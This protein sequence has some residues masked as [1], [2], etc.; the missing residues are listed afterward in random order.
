[1]TAASH[2]PVGA[3]RRPASWLDLVAHDPRPWLRTSDEPFARWVALTQLDDRPA[4]N[5]AAREAHDL[6]LAHPSVTALVDRLPEWTDPVRSHGAPAYAPNLLNLLADLGVSDE[7]GL[8][9]VTR[10]L[11]AMLEHRTPQGRF[12]AFATFIRQPEPAWSTLACDHYVITEVLVRFGREDDPRVQ[13][14]LALIA[15]DIVDTSMGVGCRCLPHSRTR[16][17]GPGR[18]ADP[19][20]Q[21]TAEAL[22]VLSRVRRPSVRTGHGLADAARTLLGVWRGRGDAKPYMFGHGLHFK[23]VK[24]PNIW[25]SSLTVLDALAAVPE[26]WHPSTADPTDSEAAAQLVACLAAYN[27]GADGRVVPRSVYRGFGEF[28]FG[29]KKHPSPIATAWVA[30]ALR[31]FDALAPLAA[32]VDVTRLASAKGGTG[33]PVPPR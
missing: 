24:W 21:V 29:Q 5:S 31:R 8:P 6:T 23:A 12:E 25:Y 9:G 13:T 33:V 17:R 16:G 11:D 28:S 7:A 3:E 2:S 22:R 27:V 30:A 10:L 15:D 26:V 4:D 14:A 18:V 1:M 19:C 32:A 20:P